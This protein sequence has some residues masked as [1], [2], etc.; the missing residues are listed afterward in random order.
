MAHPLKF[1]IRKIVQ[2][3]NIHSYTYS[4]PFLFFTPDM[5]EQML[6]KNGFEILKKRYAEFL[7]Y[8]LYLFVLLP[9]PLFSFVLFKLSNNLNA[10]SRMEKTI[11][12]IPVINKLCAYV[13]FQ[14][15]KA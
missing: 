14:A 7:Y 8:F 11:G 2:F 1:F 12:R 10:L 3:V 6:H 15:I 4:K 9:D 5:L 13:Y